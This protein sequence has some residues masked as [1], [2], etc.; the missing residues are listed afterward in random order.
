MNLVTNK[1]CFSPL[2]GP[3]L[4]RNVHLWD[5]YVG[6]TIFARAKLLFCAKFL[7]RIWMEASELNEQKA[8]LVGSL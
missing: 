7:M 2:N 8:D 1:T 6:C 3:T 5:E 4:V